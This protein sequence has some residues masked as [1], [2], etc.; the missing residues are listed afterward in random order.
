MR[1]IRCK[2][3]LFFIRLAHG[4]HRTARE[5]I[6]DGRSKYEC[7]SSENRKC[8]RR[9]FHAVVHGSDIL[10]DVDRLYGQ[11]RAKYRLRCHHHLRRC[12]ALARLRK[13]PHFPLGRI[14]RSHDVQHKRL[15]AER[16]TREADKPPLAIEDVVEETV[17][18]TAIELSL[19]RIH[20]R[21]EHGVCLC[22]RHTVRRIQ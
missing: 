1:S 4:L 11:R 2:L 3:P 5:H 8:P 21:M 12:A 18:R 14:P 17:V 15:D 9:L 16:G 22:I 6:A 13:D 7:D 19:V 10:A 20:T